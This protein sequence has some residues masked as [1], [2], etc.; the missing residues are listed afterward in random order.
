MGELRFVV[1]GVLIQLTAVVFE[2]YKTALQQ[3]TLS[4]KVNMSSL[5][6]LYYFAPLCTMF[7]LVFVLVFEVSEIR[8]RMP[9]QIGPLIFFANGVLTFA[10]NIASVTAVSNLCRVLLRE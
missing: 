9:Y 1:T 4:G 2:A 5:T 10:L 3:L 8:A 7:S 6:L